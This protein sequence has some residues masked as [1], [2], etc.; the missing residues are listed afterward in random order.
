MVIL[1]SVLPH[2]KRL[3]EWR[4]RFRT[5]L[6]ANKHQFRCS[7]NMQNNIWTI[8]FVRSIPLVAS[9][10]LTHFFPLLSL[11]LFRICDNNPCIA[12]Q[13]T[14]FDTKQ[15]LLKRE[16]EKKYMEHAFVVN[17]DYISPIRVVFIDLNA[18]RFQMWF[19]VESNTYNWCV[20]ADKQK[21]YAFAL[22]TNASDYFGTHA[23]FT[24][25]WFIVNWATFQLGL[26]T[27]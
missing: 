15:T 13:L 10:S 12:I 9:F 14:C 19:S 25:H 1:I 7:Q 6:M 16:G 4:S 5:T 18:F 22:Q 24:V 2:S 20:L 21:C 8:T 17:W 3:H 11:F 27:T 26:C 23:K